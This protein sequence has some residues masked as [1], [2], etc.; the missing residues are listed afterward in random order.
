MAVRAIQAAAGVLLLAGVPSAALADCRLLMARRAK[1]RTGL[2]ES[3]RACILAFLLFVVLF[4]GNRSAARAV[5]GPQPWPPASTLREWAANTVLVYSAKSDSPRGLGMVVS[6]TSQEVW[7]AVPAHVL[8]GHE[9]AKE[10]PSTYASGVTVSFFDDRSPRHLCSRPPTSG[11][12]PLGDIA[13]ICLQR[14]NLFPLFNDYLLGRSSVGD[15]VRLLGKSGNPGEPSNAGTATIQSVSPERLPTAGADVTATALGGE[16][17]QSGALAYT[18]RGVIGLY[19]GA[20]TGQGARILS[21][22]AIRR[23][24]EKLGIPWSLNDYEFFDCN[25]TRSVCATYA[26]GSIDSDVLLRNVFTGDE[27]S[28]ASGKCHNVPEGKYAIVATRRTLACEPTL[29][30][31]FTAQE[32]LRLSLNCTLSL[33]GKPWYSDSAG[34]L[35]C[36]PRGLAAYDCMGLQSLGRGWLQAMATTQGSKVKL[37]GQFVIAEGISTAVQGELTLTAGDRLEGSLRSASE[38]APISISLQRKD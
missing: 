23:Y 33:A 14:T 31:I 29:V 19:V 24:A 28:L 26:P 6:S 30:R 18:R 13:F 15:E 20:A 1:A 3:S 32:P 8:Y 7:V 10:P 21:A 37:N 17:G 25:L 2:G 36:M 4:I 11:G 12:G 16:E 9:G 35:S 22:S 5:C 38:E 34:E 27:A